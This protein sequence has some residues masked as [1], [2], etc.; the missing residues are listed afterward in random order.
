MDSVESV[1][2][3]DQLQSRIGRVIPATELLR[4]PTVK[5][6]IEH[7]AEEMEHKA[8]NKLELE[9]AEE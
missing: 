6:L 9:P 3:V 7:F 5:A 8:M 4:Y 1:E 2:L